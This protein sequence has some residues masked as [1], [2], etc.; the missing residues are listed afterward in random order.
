MFSLFKRVKGFY[1]NRSFYTLKSNKQNVAVRAFSGSFMKKPH[2]NIN[3]NEDE[4]MTVNFGT[5]KD[6]KDREMEDRIAEAEGWVSRKLSDEESRILNRAMGIEKELEEAENEGMMI[7][8]KLKEKYSPKKNDKKKDRLNLGKFDR[9]NPNKLNDRAA[10]LKG[11]LELNPFVCSGCGTNFQS[12]SENAPGFL[13]KDKLQIHLT[14]AKDIQEKQDAIKIL[15][16][17]G[18]DVGSLRAEDLLREAG[19]NDRIIEGIRQFGT[20]REGLQKASIT[21]VF[22]END[23]NEDY[24]DN[25]SDDE[26]YEDD[27]D[28]LEIGLDELLGAIEADQKH[29]SIAEA[30]Q[31]KIIEKAPD[32]KKE[33]ATFT[34]SS[35]SNTRLQE[36][37]SAIKNASDK[38]I[39]DLL[40]NDI[41]DEVT[42][43]RKSDHSRNMFMNADT[44]D[45]YANP[46]GKE[47][48][49]EVDVD[50][51][52]DL[53]SLVLSDR[54][55]RNLDDDVDIDA[56]KMKASNE[57]E[58][59]SVCQRCFRLEQ[60]GQVEESL[61]PGWSEHE[62]LTPERF[63][64]LISVIRENKGVVLCIVDIFDL[65]G[66]I[67]Q[68][69]KQIAGKNPIVIAANKIDLLPADTSKPRLKSWIHADIKAMCDLRGPR[70][71]KDE[72]RSEREEYG[73][74]KEKAEEVGVLRQS[75]VHLVSCKSGM[76]V[77][78]LLN[79]LMDIASYHNNKVFVMGAANVGKSSFINHL[80]SQQSP[81]QNNNKRKGNKNNKKKRSTTPMATV[82]NLPGTTLNFLNIKLPNGVTMIDTPGLINRGQLTSRLTPSELKQVIPSKPISAVS[83]RVQES[84]CI[85]IGGLASITLVEGKPFF[86]TFFISNEIKLHPTQTEKENDFLQKHVGNL[87]LPPSS[88]ERL[89]AL[90]PFVY[91][92][93]EVRGAGWGKASVDVVIAGLGWV[94]VTGVGTCKLR[95]KV[96]QGTKVDVRPALMPYETARSAASFSGGRLQKKTKKGKPGFGWRA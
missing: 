31:S 48:W 25:E 54:N 53:E 23:E 19:V 72:R 26:N 56:L 20:P 77:T 61:R 57:D 63:E 44:K 17:A 84:K 95:V 39:E 37:M 11:F 2:S 1:I 66:S 70:E 69:L 59:I 89:S 62:L 82:S 47:D 79:N 30:L 49:D 4:W 9:N 86:L 43:S 13:P 58:P 81:D 74:N 83:L 50:S 3:D 28:G 75:N 10:K 60:Y 8:G 5:E 42:S 46:G 87:V 78:A 34:A 65:E 27:L 14:S 33:K 91:E 35:N 16:L 21:S 38:S 29:S 41:Q 18:L 52:F 6:Q 80:L 67:L 22:D 7:K 32:Y 73:W 90:E 93:F 51:D 55:D 96:P 85:M 15:D 88:P 64:S 68:N 24:Y 71:V 76:G 92:D 40:V 12:K 45:L 36:Q 94:A